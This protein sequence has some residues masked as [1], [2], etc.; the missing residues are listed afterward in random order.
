MRRCGT[1]GALRI[2]ALASL[3]PSAIGCPGSAGEAPSAAPP[4]GREVGTG[5]V[6]DTKPAPAARWEDALVP[7]GTTIPLVLADK[8]D[9]ST[10]RPGNMVHA[11]VARAVLIGDFVAVPSDSVVNGFITAVTSG[12][13]GGETGGR[14]VIRFNNVSTPTGAGAGIQAHLSGIDAGGPGRPT[15]ILA[16]TPVAGPSG[17]TVVGGARGREAIL[18]ANSRI[19]ITLDQPMSI[20]VRR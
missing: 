5:F 7:A 3:L 14:I 12:K 10:S 18:E 17:S 6:P 16:A 2:L 4:T 11:T 19:S 9:S 1:S 20:K 15:P 13:E 8:L